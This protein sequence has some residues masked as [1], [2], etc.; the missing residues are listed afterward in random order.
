VIDQDV[1]K[2]APLSRVKRVALWAALFLSLLTIGAGVWF[3]VYVVGKGPGLLAKDVVVVIPKGA[4]VRTIGQILGDAGLIYNDIRFSLLARLSGYSGHLQAGE[5]L[6][7]SGK[8]P[9]EVIKDLAFAR[10]V[11][12]SV[13]II[14]GLRAIEIAEVLE[15]KGWCKASEFIS[16]VQEER[17][18]QSLGLE[19]LTS[20]EG[21][22]Y[23]DTYRLTADMRGAEKIITMMVGRFFQVWEEL[24][25]ET[26]LNIVREEAVILASI[27]EKETAAE[28]ERS[29]I[30][31][32]FKNRLTRGMRLQSDPTV[33]YGIENF[34]GRITRKQ[35]R[36]PTPYNTY[37]ISGLPVGP[38]CNPGKEALRAAINPAETDYFY[39]VSKNN[40][41]HQFSASLQEHNRAV[42]K[43][44]KKKKNKVVK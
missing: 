28:A 21:Y 42:R 5:F 1:H 34:S 9:G 44:Q 30:A 43:Y 4:S 7:K 11:Q 18:I 39:F 2:K 16:L 15:R 23:P 26:A 36:S 10:P 29:L 13:T 37:T 22:L 12:H 17:F 31:G 6:L 25:S 35:L 40:G 24:I 14:E 3:G 19:N 27:V 8:K 38:I 20:L 41:E 32:V 33:I